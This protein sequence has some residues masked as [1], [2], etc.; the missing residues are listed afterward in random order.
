[1]SSLFL[2][3]VKFFLVVLGVF[4]LAGGALYVLLPRHTAYAPVIPQELHDDP[5]SAHE[6]EQKNI[7]VANIQQGD[8]VSFPLVI[9]GQARVFENVVEYRVV[10]DTGSVLADGFVLADSPDVGMFGSFTETIYFDAP[11]TSSGALEVFS[12]SPADGSPENMVRLP[13][14]FHE[15]EHVS[16]DVSLFFLPRDSSDCAT[17]IPVSRRIPKVPSVAYET[18]QA[19]LR[20]IRSSERDAFA[21]AL[22][23]R[24]SLRSLF[25]ENGVATVTFAEGSFSGVAGSCTVGSIRAQ[26][27][28]TLAQ[29]PSITSV[30]LLEEGKTSAE[31]LQ[32]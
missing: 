22:P 15:D 1:M 24:A 3:R 8:A 19:L 5:S 14:T 16:R 4:A 23:Q 11:Q 9:S 32:P 28:A 25:I 29:F 27:E 2:Q 10:D 13:I 18:L 20:G 17:V 7:H 21:T 12:S 31:T 6:F 26:I 30:V